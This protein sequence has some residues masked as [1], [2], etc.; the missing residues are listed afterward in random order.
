MDDV[1]TILTVS[2]GAK[3][4]T[5]A[6]AALFCYG[7]LMV[8]DWLNADKFGKARRKI[9]TNPVASAVYYGARFFA[10]LYLVATILR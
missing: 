4:V 1:Q 8:L 9:L 3:L 10:V 6:L 7:L 2:F 5:A